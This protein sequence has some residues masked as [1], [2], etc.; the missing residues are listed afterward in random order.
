MSLEDTARRAILAKAI[1]TVLGS[2]GGHSCK[3]DVALASRMLLRGDLTPKQHNGWKKSGRPH[4][5][6]WAALQQRKMHKHAKVWSGSRWLL[7]L[8]HV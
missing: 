7:V 4:D 6:A 8:W 5:D 1:A 2:N 3:Y